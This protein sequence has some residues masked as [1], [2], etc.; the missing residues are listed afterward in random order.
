MLKDQEIRILKNINNLG[1]VDFDFLLVSINGKRAKSNYRKVASYRLRKILLSLRER[2]FIR[3][4][5]SALGEKYYTLEDV[6]KI[7]IERDGSKLNTNVLMPNSSLMVHHSRIMR[8]VSLLIYHFNCA[9]RTEYILRDS[10]SNKTIPDFIAVLYK[11]R[12]VFEIERSQKSD[13]LLKSKL[14]SYN[15][16]YHNDYIVYLT[17][18]KNLADKINKIKHVHANSSRVFAF[19]ISTFL[20]DC[21][22]KVS[23]MISSE[24]VQEFSNVQ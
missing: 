23:F 10:V 19:E 4:S 20:N 12:F 14:A 16:E 18:T 7:I 15:L 24:S 1:I 21:R 3:E 5:F 9:Y 17:E 2:S 13:D 6:S 22:G 11:K 8:V